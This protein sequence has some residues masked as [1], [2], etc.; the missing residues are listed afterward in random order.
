ME[1][2]WK[3][4][5]NENISNVQANW[6]FQYFLCKY[7]MKKSDGDNI[8]MYDNEQDNKSKLQG[9]RWGWLNSWLN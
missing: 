4:Q 3:Y 1:V 7:N 2:R 9:H 5:E 6:N 8:G